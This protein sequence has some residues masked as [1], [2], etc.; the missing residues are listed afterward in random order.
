M[1]NGGFECGELSEWMGVMG[2]LTVTSTGAAEGSHAAQ[3]VIDATGTGGIGSTNPVVAKTSGKVYCASA[4]VRGTVSDVRLEVFGGQLTSFGSPLNSP[5]T[6]VRLPPSTN[7]EIREPVDQKL[8]VKVRAQNGKAGDTLFVDDID[9]WESAD[10]K[11][12]ER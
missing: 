6:W 1:V 7:L 4:K 2:T 8:Y 3:I 5:D 12:K 9:L 11:C 10:G